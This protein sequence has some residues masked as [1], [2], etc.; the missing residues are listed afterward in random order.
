MSV[1]A[2][3]NETVSENTSTRPESEYRIASPAELNTLSTQL[4]NN[5]ASCRKSHIRLFIL[6]PLAQKSILDQSRDY[7]S[8]YARNEHGE[9]CGLTDNEYTDI[10]SLSKAWRAAWATFPL[11]DIERVIFDIDT[12]SGEVEWS[13]Y[14]TI[15]EDK[16]TVH[17]NTQQLITLVNTMAL[18]LHQRTMNEGGIVMQLEGNGPPDR[19]V[20]ETLGGYLEALR[21]QGKSWEEKRKSK[22]IKGR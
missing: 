1:N 13:G 3:N 4:N 6:H 16:V 12:T 10:S 15:T 21:T 11:F 5:Q 2:I 17:V 9:R 7:D 19:R 14:Q 18:V 20:R 22:Y 8:R